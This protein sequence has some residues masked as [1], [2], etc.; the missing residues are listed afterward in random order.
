[1]NGNMLEM[2]PAAPSGTRCLPSSRPNVVPVA[3][4]VTKENID[5]GLFK[6]K[7]AP[8]ETLISGVSISGLTLSN[9]TFKLRS[10]QC[11][12]LE[13]CSRLRL[14]DVVIRGTRQADNDRYRC[15]YHTDSLV[16][17]QIKSAVTLKNRYTL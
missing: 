3:R 6:L 5:T 8:Q 12:I 7:Q 10:D 15:C 1:M 2:R 14:Q 9:V 16:A 13:L 11:L 17:V 4:A